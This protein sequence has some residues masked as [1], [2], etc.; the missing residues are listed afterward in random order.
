MK[1]GTKI[2]VRQLVAAIVLI[3]LAVARL[4]WPGFAAKADAASLILVAVGLALLIVPLKSIKTLKAGGVELSLDAPP[5]QG[6]V[7]SLNLNRIEDAKLKSRL[8]TLSHLLPVV[9]G[10]RLL[11]IDDRPEKIIGERRLLRALG[12]TVVSA[13][14]SE[15]ARDILNADNDFDLILSDVQ[16]RGE[17]HSITGGVAIHEGVNFIVWLRTR[18]DDGFVSAIPVIFYAAYDWSR[19]VEFTRPA[20]ETAPEPGIANSIADLVP[21]V[22]LA[23]ADSR[24]SAIQ[25]PS[26]KTPTGIRTRE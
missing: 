18:A 16:R 12:V 3:A 15:H 7:A 24:Q 19:L 25:L 22:I 8:Q 11:W 17:T 1:T 2:E 21:K 9:A 26:E 10:A 4:F 23:L 5:V 6:A 13:I 20:R 14:S